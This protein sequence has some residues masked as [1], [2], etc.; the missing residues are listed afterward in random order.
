MERFAK[1]VAAAVLVTCAAVCV[2]SVRGAA[3]Q[4]DSS[5]PKAV[6]VWSVM[7]S[8]IDT[9]LRGLS[10]VAPPRGAAGAAVIWASGS[11]GVVLK[12]IDGGKNWER[13]AVPGGE[14]LDFRGVRAFSSAAAY[15]MSSGPGDKSKIF[16]TT[17]G[18]AT[19]KMQFT[20]TR[21]AFFLDA[22]VCDGEIR[23]VAL[24]DPVDGK[25]VI[26]RTTDGE[27]WQIA[28]SAGMP[29]A[30]RT[31]EHLRRAIR[32]SRFFAEQAR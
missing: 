15:A 17:D 31:K 12:S 7:T 25:F 19:W 27:T 32:A 30:R 3:R 21:A 6:A 28:P 8:G 2:I 11:S 4:A 14:E 24:S 1:K 13:I 20:D 29:D 10:V 26:V 16:K 5:A 9:D 22:I 23:C 18:G